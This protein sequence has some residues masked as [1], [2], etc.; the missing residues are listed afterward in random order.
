M[1]AKDRKNG[2]E[3]DPER[4]GDSYITQYFS[5]G[6]PS[7]S[8]NGAKRRTIKPYAKHHNCEHKPFEQKDARIEADAVRIRCRAHL[9]RPGASPVGPNPQ[10]GEHAYRVK[11][12]GDG[13][14]PI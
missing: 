11:W 14:V 10:Y 4:S 2:R 12:G 7:I 3:N 8:Q 9:I 13:A 6:A 1:G 5:D